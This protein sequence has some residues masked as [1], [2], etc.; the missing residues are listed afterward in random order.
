M[1]WFQ[2]AIEEIRVALILRGLRR[3]QEYRRSRLNAGLFVLLL[4]L[5]YLAFQVKY[6]GTLEIDHE[7]LIIK[8]DLATRP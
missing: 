5:L 6:S 4:V 1:G 2:R 7:P 3:P 8:G